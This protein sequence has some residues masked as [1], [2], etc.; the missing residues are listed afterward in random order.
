MNLGL[1]RSV[2]GKAIW[3][4]GKQS[5]FLSLSSSLY[6]CF[7][8]FLWFPLCWCFCWL[9]CTW[10]HV[11]TPQCPPQPP[12][13]HHSVQA[14]DPEWEWHLS[15]KSVFQEKTPWLSL[16]GL[17]T[18]TWCNQLGQWPVSPY[19]HD[20]LWFLFCVW[21]QALLR[22]VCGLSG[23][24]KPCLL[25]VAKNLRIIES[26]ELGDQLN[27]GMREK[28]KLEMTRSVHFQRWEPFHWRGRQRML[29]ERRSL[30][31]N[32]VRKRPLVSRKSSPLLRF[33]LSGELGVTAVQTHLFPWLP[34]SPGL[35]HSDLC[36]M[37]ST[38]PPRVGGGH[39]DFSL[40]ICLKCSCNSWQKELPLPTLSNP[41]PVYY[42]K[43][44][45]SIFILPITVAPKPSVGS[46]RWAICTC[47][48]RE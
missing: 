40:Q 15:L 16:I 7:S 35:P 12:S 47:W 21:R 30:W 19:R 29:G 27:V 3:N 45:K 18:Q 5:L 26:R 37:T 34:P 10:H 39:E 46:C 1:K 13:L 24:S 33:Q 41:V 2:T 23:H 25:K 17:G 48:M 44:E 4:T 43:R 6:G 31:K 38:I 36:C 14:K 22:E 42:S 8:S 28:E 11:T 32:S 20:S 9:P